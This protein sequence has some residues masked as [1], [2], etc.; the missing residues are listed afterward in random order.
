MAVDAVVGGAVAGGAVAVGAV[1][2]LWPLVR[3]RHAVAGDAMVSCAAAGGVVAAGAEAGAAKAGAVLVSV[4]RRVVLWPLVPRLAL[5]RLAVP[6]PA[7]PWPPVPS[8]AV[9]WPAVPWPPVPWPAVMWRTMRWR[10][11]GRRARG[12]REPRSP[13]GGDSDPAEA[14]PARRALRPGCLAG[15]W[16]AP[17][18]GGGSP[19]GNRSSCGRSQERHP[20]PRAVSQ[21]CRPGRSRCL[22]LVCR[23]PSEPGRLVVRGKQREHRPAAI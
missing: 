10:L 18:Q 9:P 16:G 5:S 17:E 22:L 21:R 12:G 11:A 14:R 6:W 7:V 15:S 20:R 13:G 8:W 4:R 23:G 2:G 19:S 1:A 3:W